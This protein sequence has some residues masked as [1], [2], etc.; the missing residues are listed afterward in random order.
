MKGKLRNLIST[1]LKCFVQVFKY[2]YYACIIANVQNG[3]LSC[4]QKVIPRFVNLANKTPR[5]D[6]KV[7]FTETFSRE[8][9]LGENPAYNVIYLVKKKYV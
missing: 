7:Y 5:K 6:T 4:L 8:K 9:S 3:A 1:L 2:S